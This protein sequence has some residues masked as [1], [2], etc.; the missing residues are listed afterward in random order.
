[1]CLIFAR[2]MPNVSYDIV[3]LI[4]EA[5]RK[6][7][8]IPIFS[9]LDKNISQKEV[10]PALFLE[11]QEQGVCCN[12][13]FLCCIRKTYYILQHTHLVFSFKK[14]IIIEL[15]GRTNWNEC[16]RYVLIISNSH[17]TKITRSHYINSANSFFIWHQL[18]NINVEE[19]QKA[20]TI[21]Q[22]CF[23]IIIIVMIIIIVIFKG[24]VSCLHRGKNTILKSLMT[25]YS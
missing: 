16:E 14:I 22:L 12:M 13:L 3:S 25:L 6:G 21:V 19:H 18:M 24:N 10:S 7:A 8:I 1:M 15:H 5:F 2:K 4:K 20:A 17:G 11:M 9:Q 23:I